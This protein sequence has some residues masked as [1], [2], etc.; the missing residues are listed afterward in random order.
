MSLLLNRSFTI[1]HALEEKVLYSEGLL[2]Y[3]VKIYKAMGPY[4]NFL[5]R[6]MEG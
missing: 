1:S 3:T 2:D 5:A 6:A 4:N